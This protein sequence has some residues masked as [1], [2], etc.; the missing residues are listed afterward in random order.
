MK[1]KKFLI[2]PMLMA[3]S[4]FGVAGTQSAAQAQELL[5]QG[6]FDQVAANNKPAGWDLKF[7]PENVSL[8]GDAGNRWLQLRD[9]AVIAQVVKFP[10]RAKT[11]VV[12][13]RLK[14][15]NY[16]KGP[17]V[18]HRARISMTFQNDKGEKVGAYPPIV[19]LTANSDWVA[20]EVTNTV[21]VGATQVLLEPGLW[22]SKGLFEIDDLVV[23][24]TEIA[25]IFIPA[26]A[27][28]PATQ[29][30]A[31]GEEPVDVQSSKRAR[32]SLN[33]AWKF[34]PQVNVGEQAGTAPEKGWGYMAVPGN[35]RRYQEVIAR[36]V[37]PQWTQLD[38][39]ALGRAW[40]ERRFKVPADWDGRHI[41]IDFDRISTDATFWV[42][43]KPA[44]KVNFP[45]GEID[46]TGLVKAGEEV[47]LRAHVVA[48]IQPGKV[49]VLMGEAPGQNWEV[50]AELKS[51]GLVGNVTLQSRPRGA[52]VSD[53]YVQ[54]SVRKKQLGVDIELSGV[55]QNG[56][57]QLVA[58]LVDE[59]G[60]EEKRFT[61]TV[62]A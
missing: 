58:S 33:G 46:I 19:D 8:A 23:K 17:E 49:A 18:W 11:F 15:S 26:D 13:A 5:P 43:G 54:P 42:N 24:V 35:W 61:Q 52:Y 51:A 7:G 25:P 45:E 55:T 12:S 31:W 10:V 14:L 37:G 40:Y 48:T 4:Y 2:V 59:N 36:G 60:K 57:V 9:G 20:K 3:T 34:S 39:R 62:N 6:T 50:D 44:G 41:S 16:V 30:V 38:L 21:P 53:V 22:G 29:K 28:W 27:P 32:V 47:T 1:L 56:P